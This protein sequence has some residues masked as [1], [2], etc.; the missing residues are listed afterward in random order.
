MVDTDYDSPPRAP[1][2]KQQNKKQYGKKARRMTVGVDRAS[3]KAGERVRKESS[4]S[5][6]VETERR[7]CREGGKGKEGQGKGK[8]VV[9]REGRKRMSK[10]ENSKEVEGV[11]MTVSPRG[12]F[13][14][15]STIA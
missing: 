9:Q 1:R 12:S 13:L 6:E 8:E 7:R 11:A 14:N 3:E 5:E 2:A 10:V 15:F 4:E